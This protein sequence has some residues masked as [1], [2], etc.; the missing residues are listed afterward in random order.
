MWLN[1]E[2][3]MTVLD[4]APLVSIDLVIENSEGD[5]LLGQ[6]VNRPAQGYW[7]VPGGRILKGESLDDAF[8]RLSKTE[9]GLALHRGDARLLDVYEHFY[10]DS[11]FGATGEG[12]STHYV[13]LGYHLR[14][15]NALPE[16][17]PHQQHTEYRWASTESILVDPLVHHHTRAYFESFMALHSAGRG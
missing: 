7:F 4:A 5:F 15:S 13:A 1:H 14:I 8:S 9:L 6:R 10:T 3:F 17:L 2:T 12:P 16:L 11:V